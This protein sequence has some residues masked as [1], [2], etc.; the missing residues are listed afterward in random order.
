MTTNKKKSKNERHRNIYLPVL[1]IL[2][3]LN[4]LSGENMYIPDHIRINHFQTLI[5]IEKVSLMIRYLKRQFNLAY[6]FIKFK[7]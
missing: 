5:N 1:D 3:T 6:N 2:W 7:R 4:P